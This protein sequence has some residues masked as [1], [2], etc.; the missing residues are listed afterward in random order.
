MWP[1]STLE[2]VRSAISSRKLLSSSMQLKLER[3]A[4]KALGDVVEEFELSVTR[5]IGI[6]IQSTYT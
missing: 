2:G 4:D 5:P 6:T 1:K 3:P